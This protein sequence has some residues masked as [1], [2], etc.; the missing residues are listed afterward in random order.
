[1][2]KIASLDK[3]YLEKASSFKPLFKFDKFSTSV[4]TDSLA[5]IWQT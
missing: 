3:C 2:G 4:K 1:M 5:G